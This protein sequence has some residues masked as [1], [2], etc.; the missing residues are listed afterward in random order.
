MRADLSLTGERKE[1][2]PRNELEISWYF[3][4]HVWTTSGRWLMRVKSRGKY[5]CRGRRERKTILR[6]KIIYERG[7]YGPRGAV[8]ETGWMTNKRTTILNQVK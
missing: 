6:K 7:K 1:R 3:G 5:G 8:M 4:G 2:N